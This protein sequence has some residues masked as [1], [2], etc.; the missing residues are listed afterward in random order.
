MEGSTLPPGTSTAGV[1]CPFCSGG[2][3]KDKSFSISRTTDGNLVYF[4]HRA[5]CG[6]SGAIKGTVNFIALEGGKSKANL[7]TE[8]TVALSDNQYLFFAKRY[9]MSKEE[10]NRAGFLFVP[11]AKRICQP[12]YA[13]EGRIRGYAL[14]RYLDKQISVYRAVEGSTEPLISWYGDHSKTDVVLV[15][16]QLSA[17][18]LSRYHRAVALLGVNLSISA[19][20]EIC[21]KSSKQ[22][23]AL[24]RDAI[25]T[26][27]KHEYRWKNILNISILNIKK[28]PKY[29]D[30]MQ[31]S[32]LN[33]EASP[34]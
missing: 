34:F 14:R 10:L 15:E 31:L 33:E 6:K 4:C 21:T 17:I 22:Y 8:P 12:I 28:D 23:L 5:K 30:N 18:K 7:F 24:D 13:P 32:S 2:I 9:G 11:T 26:A 16:D 20:I 1:I 29:W 27:L 3:N 19:I 25:I